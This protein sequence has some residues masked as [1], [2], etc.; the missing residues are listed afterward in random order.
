MALDR[1]PGFKVSCSNR[2]CLGFNKYNFGATLAMRNFMHMRQVV[3]KK[4]IS[5]FFYVLLWFKPRPHL[6]DPF[7]TLGS[8]FEK[9]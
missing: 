9:N 5:L 4:K 7:R 1:S 6:E 3:L 8:L 2:M